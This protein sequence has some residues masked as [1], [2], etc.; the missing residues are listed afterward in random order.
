MNILIVD[1]ERIIR[2]WFRMTVDKLGG[3][4][5]IIGEA[6]GGEEA[7]EFCR[8]H[9]VDLV[10]TDV[11]MPGMNGLELIKQLKEEQPAVRTV[12]FSSYGEF[13]F[14]AEALKL[15]ANEYI[16]KA[17]ITLSGLEDILQKIK[18][19]IELERSKAVELNYLRHVLNQNEQVLRTAYLRE[20]LQGSG[21]AAQQFASKMSYF[22]IRLQEKNLALMAFGI[23]P[24]PE[25]SQLINDPDLLQQA[26]VNIINETLLTETDG[27]CSFLYMNEVYMLLVNAS[28]SG[29]KSQRELLQLTAS[30]VAE[31]ARRFLGVESAIGISMTYSSL[32][33]LPEQAREAL[34]ALD[35]KRFYGDRSV[36]YFQD[37]DT[38]PLNPDHWTQSF[39]P[40]VDSF[41]RLLEEGKPQEALQQFD[42]VLTKA[43][44]EKSLSP[45]Q[46]K[47]VVLELIYSAIN[48]AR[49]L[50]VPLDKL[51]ALSTEVTEQIVLQEN[52]SQ[53]A[54]WAAGAIREL[55]DWL[56]ATRPRYAEPVEKA[57]EYI[58]LNFAGEI[59][60]KEVSMHV[61]LSR[62][63]FSELF[64]KETGLNFN[65]YVMQVRMV[66][67]KSILKRQQMRI[68]DVAAQVGYAN[69]SYFIKLFKKYAGVS[70]Y[71]YMESYSSFRTR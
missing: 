55:M 14:A 10:V 60:L 66:Q 21:Q 50:Q 33:Y 11:K 58:R 26:I 38:V 69:P 51:E 7:L 3:D 32:S 53:L 49:S 43:G 27:G 40:H 47:A 59:T 22:G 23:I 12:I 63:Y 42:H 31:N 9:P 57:C 71:E 36:A 28:A 24:G 39:K 2:E 70:P 16:L 34:E 15:G 52:Y 19:D 35:R 45:K 25:K 54:V 64:K 65:E 67:A 48:W 13:H 56:E 41:H 1:D 62:T 46:M 30:R 29:M 20:L 17:E 61:H 37:S 8:Q 5:R 4:C 68:A 6:A 44:E 18:R